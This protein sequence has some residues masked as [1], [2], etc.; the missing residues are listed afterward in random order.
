MKEKPCFRQLINYNTIY[1][2]NWTTNS[3]E[4]DSEILSRPL[5]NNF[6]KFGKIDTEH[7]KMM[8]NR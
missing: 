5:N 4:K 2:N 6:I 8:K 1:S 3:D 7:V